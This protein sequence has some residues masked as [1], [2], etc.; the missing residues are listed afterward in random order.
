[1][2]NKIL[3][4]LLILTIISGIGIVI[5]SGQS[6][7]QELNILKVPTGI[8]PGDSFIDPSAVIEVLNLSNFSIGKES[9]IAPF[10]YIAG[11]DIKIGNYTSIQ[12]DVEIRGLPKI[13][14][15]VTIAHGSGLSGKVEIGEKTFI[16]F[17][18]FIQSSKIGK[19]VYIG[20]SSVVSNVTIPDYTYINPGSNINKQLLVE[21]LTDIN[22][23]QKEFIEKIIAENSL[24]I[25][26]SKLYKENKS[27]FG[28]IGPNPDGDRPVIE[29][30][31]EYETVKII[32]DVFIGKNSKIGNG[33]VIRADKG[34]IKIGEA[35]LIGIGNVFHS[36]NNES[37]EIGEN[38]NL[39]NFNVIHGPLKIGNNA[40]IGDRTVVF[41]S[42]IGN[43]V[44]IGNRAIVSNVDIPDGTNIGQSQKIINQKD[45][46]NLKEFKNLVNDTFKNKNNT[47]ENKTVPGFDFVAIICLFFMT[48][49]KN[50]KK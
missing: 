7:T 20:H 32:G 18:T 45:L 14:D 15:N 2:N 47:S 25:K 16:G 10:A 19:G 37:I 33:A 23:E 6:N 1:M 17:N 24:A 41:N 9:Y 8:Y 22:Q 11:R 12:D 36:F 48:C 3:N 44:T 27:V 39:R 42:K 50:F 35:A 4:I 28:P 29:K 40:S 34:S 5:G 26:Y 46:E 21:N 30:D 43:N 31:V 49:V 38:F 13:S